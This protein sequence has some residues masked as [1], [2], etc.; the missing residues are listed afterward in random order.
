MRFRNP[1]GIVSDRLNERKSAGLISSYSGPE[2]LRLP[3]AGIL[4]EVKRLY[5]PEDVDP[6]TYNV[7]IEGI[8]KDKELGI[9]VEGGYHYTNG[10]YVVR[11]NP[12]DIPIELETFGYGDG[13]DKFPDIAKPVAKRYLGTP[14]ATSIESAFKDESQE[15]YEKL[16]QNSDLY[17][18]L[19]RF[20][21]YLQ[22]IGKELVDGHQESEV[23][24]DPQF[25][26]MVLNMSQRYA[27]DREIRRHHLVPTNVHETSHQIM[28]EQTSYGDFVRRIGNDRAIW[29]VA[30]TEHRKIFDSDLRKELDTAYYASDK[31]GVERICSELI[32]RK[33]QAV[34]RQLGNV[35]K[36]EYGAYTKARGLDENLARVVNSK[37]TGTE[38][39]HDSVTTF[40]YMTSDVDVGGGSFDRIQEF[41]R[42]HKYHNILEMGLEDFVRKFS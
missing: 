30:S 5:A 13:K 36:E 2:S 26:Q 29:E 1:F 37:L 24:N 14:L 23:V 20:I 11:I 4:G 35:K 7:Q 25:V 17:S 16:Q 8:G 22:S 28:G 38:E 19:D 9:A 42:D 18:P 41:L 40:A 21:I 3:V 10:R 6:G 31:E 34:E 32:Q 39:D 15:L 12:F 33:A 27:R